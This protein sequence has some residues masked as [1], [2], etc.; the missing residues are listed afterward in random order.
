MRASIGYMDFKYF[1]IF[2]NPFRYVSF[3]LHSVHLFFILN[4]TLK[5]LFSFSIFKIVFHYTENNSFILMTATTSK[6]C[7]M[8][9]SKGIGQFKCEDGSNILYRTSTN[10]KSTIRGDHFS[11]MM[12]SNKQIRRIRVNL[13][14][15]W[16]ISNNGKN[17]PLIKFDR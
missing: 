14:L 6:V 9:F 12:L 16:L 5:I 2:S 17:D 11:N 10:I 8:T 15:S 3:T 13:H 4:K 7:C 1:S